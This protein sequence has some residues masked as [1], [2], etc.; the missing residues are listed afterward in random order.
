MP[1]TT[2]IADHIA[3][4]VI[5][6]PPVNALPVTGWFDIAEHVTLPAL[7]LLPLVALLLGWSIR[8]GLRPL[9]RL[10]RERGGRA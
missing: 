6:Y 9:E 1:V 5:D 2:H 8:R 4:I 3:E 7:L 10:S